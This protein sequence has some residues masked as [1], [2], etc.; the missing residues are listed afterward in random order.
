[1]SQINPDHAT[2]YI[3]CSHLRPGLPSGLF[4]SGFPIESLYAPLPSPI[5]AKCPVHLILLHYVT[6]TTSLLPCPVRYHAGTTNIL[7][8][9]ASDKNH[10]KPGACVKVN[11]A[12]TPGLWHRAAYE[13]NDVSWLRREKQAAAVHNTD[14][15]T[16]RQLWSRQRT[17]ATSLWDW[18]YRYTLK[19]LWQ[20][21]RHYITVLSR[22]LQGCQHHKNVQEMV[23]VIQWNTKVTIWIDDTAT[24]TETDRRNACY[25]SR[26][27]PPPWFN[28][29]RWTVSLLT[30]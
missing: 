10:S 12:V 24:E 30:G 20:I 16:D 25:T 2:P 1:M 11:T 8:L 3:L 13:E 27:F 5:R 4:P 19:G 6:I 15:Q 7:S 18:L 22:P 21:N 9:K 29:T 28:R 23:S 17:D 14:R 26:A